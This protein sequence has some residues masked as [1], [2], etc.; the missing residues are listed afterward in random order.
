MK[1]KHNLATRLGG[2]FLAAI[3]LL[4]ILPVSTIAMAVGSGEDV[5]VTWTP[6]TQTQNGTRTVALTAQLV[7]S[8]DTPVAAMVEIS[9]TAEEAGALSWEGE[10]ISDSDLAA[11]SGE[12]TDTDTNTPDTEGSQDSDEGTTQAPDTE[13]SQDSDPE[14]PQDP[15]PDFQDPS[16]DQQEA[17]GTEPSDSD[18][19]TE[20]TETP[21]A[22]VT[23]A[24]SRTGGEQAM[25]IEKSNDGGAVLRI[26]LSEEAYT[27]TKEL[28]FI[29]E[30]DTTIHVYNSDIKVKT[31]EAESVPTNITAVGLLTAGNANASITTSDFTV[32]AHIPEEIEVNASRGTVDLDGEGSKDIAYTVNLQ[33]IA[34]GEGGKDYTLSVALPEGLSLPAGALSYSNS[35][36]SIQ[37][38]ETQIATLKLPGGI[39]IKDD[40]LTATDNSFS[41]IATVPPAGEKETEIE[42]HEITFTLHADKLARSSEAFTGSVSLTVNAEGEGETAMASAAATV[43][44]GGATLPGEGGWN[45]QITKTE[46]LNQN[47]FWRDNEQTSARPE[48]WADGIF[49]ST[50]AKLYYTL[51]DENGVTYERTLLTEDTLKYVGLTSYPGFAV[52]NGHGFTVEDLPHTIQQVDPNDE[53]NVRNTYTIT[54]SLE[55]PE[56]VAGY[57]FR[58]ISESQTGEGKEYPSIDTPGWYYM[59]K[60]SFTFTLNI[61][62]GEEDPLGED[63]ERAARLR[64]LLQNFQFNWS[65][66][67]IEDSNGILD[68]IEAFHAVPSYNEGTITINGMWKYNVDGSPINYSVT[69]IKGDDDDQVTPDYKITAEE[70]GDEESLLEDGEW[71]QI[72]YVNT[73]VPGEGQDT[74]A[75]HSGGT[76]Q[77]VR[78]GNTQYEATKIWL[79]SY[80]D[81]EGN[82]R[83]TANFTLYR[84]R[85]GEDPSTAAQ[86]NGY[87]IQ[88]KNKEAA[89]GYSVQVM[90]EDGETTALADLPKYDTLD[91]A[92]FIYVVR[93]TLSGDNAGQ[94]EQVFGTVTVGETGKIEKTTATL[95][96]GALPDGS[97]DRPAGNTYLYNDGTLTNYQ[98]GTIPVSATKTWLAAAYQST[99]D[100]VAVELTLQYREKDSGG[101]GEWK[102]YTDSDGKSVIRYLH[103]FYAESLSDT[104]MDPPSM[105]QYQ[106]TQISTANQELEYRWLETAVY[107]GAANAEENN[108][109]DATGEIEI[110]YPKSGENS[111]TGNNPKG[112]FNINSSNY[113]V[114]YA[115][116]TNNTQI[117][118][119][120]AEYLDYEVIKEWHKD[121]TPGLIT[122]QIL[123]SVAGGDF[124]E[125]LE[126]TMN[127][128]VGG[129]VTVTGPTTT[130]TDV[131]KEFKI[132]EGAVVKDSDDDT[133][134]KETWNAT[135]SGLPRFDKQGRPYEYLLLEKG[136][137]PTYQTEIDDRGN[138]TTTVING[139]GDGGFNL[140]VRKVWLDD[141]DMEHREPVTFTLY[142]KNNDEPVTLNGIPYTITLGGENEENLWHKVVRI[143]TTGLGNIDEVGYDDKF[144]ADDIYLVE[145]LVGTDKDGNPNKVNHKETNEQAISYNYLYDKRTDGEP[146]F[147]VKTTNHRYQVTYKQE[148]NTSNDPVASSVGAAFTI[149]NRRLGSIDLTVT[150]DWVD[151]REGNSAQVQ[152]QIKAVLENYAEKKETRL[153]LAFR[154]VFDDSM[155]DKSQDCKITYSG[156]SAH[157]DTVCVGGEDVQIYSTYQ[158]DD[159]KSEGYDDP[160]SSEWIILGYVKDEQ[161]NWT[162]TTDNSAQFLGL[163]KYDTNGEIVAYSIEEVWLDV[164]EADKNNPPTVV[165]FDIESTREEYSELYTLWQDFSADYQWGEYDADVDG[166]HTRDE[167]TLKVTNARRGSKT[168]QWTV[169]WQ[170]DFTLNSD[171]RPDIYLDIYQVTY[172]YNDDGSRTP[173]I[174][175]VTGRTLDWDMSNSG[176]WTATMSGVP[177]FDEKGNEI[178]YYAVQR[179]VMAAG[180]YDYQVAQYEINDTALGTRDD[181]AEGVEALNST[182]GSITNTDGDPYNLAVLGKR[183][184]ET[185][186]VE[187]IAWKGNSQQPTNIGRFGETN[188]YPKYALLEGGTIINTLAETYTIEGVKYWTNLPNGWEDSRLPQVTFTVSRH[189][190]DKENEAKE[191]AKVVISSDLWEK[192]RSGTQYKYLIAYE[193]INVLGKESNDENGNGINGEVYVKEVLDMNGEA[194]IK[195]PTP[196]PRYQSGTG[197]L[198]TYT[199]EETVDWGTNKPDDGYKIFDNAPG[200][201]G[202][203]FT[204]NY[205]PTTGSIQVKKYLY[206][207]MT[208]TNAGGM[209]VPESYPAV[210]FRLERWLQNV[211]SSDY[212]PDG[213]S[214][215]ITL[216]SDQVKNI[217]NN[218]NADGTAVT[219]ENLVNSGKS[220]SGDAYIWATLEFADLPLYA[221]DGTKYQYSV[222]EVKTWLNGYDT[223]GVKGDVPEGALD[224]S[225]VE[226]TK[227]N[228]TNGVTESID[229]LTPTTV[230]EGVAISPAATFKNQ[231]PKNQEDF[232]QLTAIKIWED[233]D[234]S[235][236]PSTNDFANLLTLTRTAA[237][238]GGTGGADGI[239][240]ELV[241]GAD[242]TISISPETGTESSQWTITITPAEGKSFEKYAPNGMEWTYT[243]KERVTEKGRLQITE[244]GN[245]DQDKIYTPSTPTPNSKTNGEWQYTITSTT[246]PVSGSDLDT[247]SFGSLTNSIMT[248]AKFEKE[249]VDAE[250][251]PITQDY[252]GFDLTV[253]FQL[254]VREMGGDDEDWV[255]ASVWTYSDGTNAN[256]TLGLEER[257]TGCLSG[258]VVNANHNWTYTFEN[259]PGVVKDSEKKYIFLE[260]RVIETK[261]SWDSGSQIIS[262][263]TDNTGNIGDQDRFTYGVDES[264]ITDATF[265]RSDNTS[266]TTNKLATTSVS[267]TKVWDD[268]NN[269]YGTRPG[270]EGPWSW[271]SWFV[272]QRTTTPNDDNSWTN[273]ALFQ[274]LYGSNAEGKDAGGVSQQGKW[275]DTITGLPTMD[276][277]GT[278]AQKYTYRVRELQPKEDG[279][280]SVNEVISDGE[281]KNI[282]DPNGTYNPD[283]FHYTATYTPPASNSTLWTVTNSMD[284]PTLED[285][286]PKNVEAIKRWVGSDNGSVSSVTFQL[287]Y[288]TE[289]SEW[290]AADFLSGGQWEKTA[291]ASNHWTVRWEDLPDTDGSN[292]QVT[293]YQV[294]EKASNGWVQIGEPVI[295]HDDTTGTTTYSYTFTNSIS[296]SY[297]V[298]KEWLPSTAATHEVTLGLYRTT[299]QEDVG[300]ISGTPV[301]VDELAT[302]GAKRTVTLD[303]I[304]DTDG[305]EKETWKTTFSNLPKYNASGQEY[306]YYAL[307]LDGNNNP[308]VQNGTIVLNNADYEVSYS[309]A[310]DNTKTTVTNTTA[311]SL[312]GTKTWKDDSNEGNTRPTNL[313]LILERRV[314]TDEW[315]EDLAGTYPPTWNKPEGSNEWTYTFS[316]LPSCDS[317]G[318]LYEY[319][320]REEVPTGYK[321]EKQKNNGLDGEVDKTGGNYDFTNIRTGTVS[322]VV[323]KTWVGDNEDDRP[324]NVTLKLERMTIND[325][326]WVDITAGITQPTWTTTGNIWSL[327]YPNLPQFDKDGVR[328]EY[329]ITEVNVPVDY[330][331]KNSTNTDPTEPYTI[332][333]IRKGAL[334]IRKEVSGNRGETDREFHF[335]VTLTGASAAGTQAADVD[336]NYT[337]VYTNQDGTT[338]TEITFT[339]GVSTTEIA[340]KD[341]ESVIISGLPAGLHYEVTETEKNTDGYSTTGTGWTGTIPAGDTAQAEFENYRNSSSSSN[342]TDVS[343]TKTWVDDSDAAGLRPDVLELT[344]YRSVD[345]GPEQVVNAAPTWTKTGNVWTYR[346]ANLPKYDSSGRTYTYRVVETVPEGYVSTVSGNNFTNTLT[347]EEEKI[348]LTGHKSWLGD[349]AEGRPESIT[350]VLYDGDGQV[351]RRVT[352][353][354]AENWSYVFADLPRYDAEGNE[355]PYYVR[356]E[357]V[358]AGYQVSY[359]GL[360]IVNRKEDAVGALRVTKQVT[361]SGAEYDRAFSFTVTLE[362]RTIN[363]T[364]GEMTFVDGVATFTL[365]HGQSVT[366]V[367]LPAGIPYTVTETMPEG[368]AASN[369]QQA[370]EIPASDLAT[371]TVV[372]H[373][374]LPEEPTNPE[375]PEGPENPDVPDSPDDPAGPEDPQGPEVQ[376]GDRANLTL[377]GG[378]AALFAA[379]LA[380]TL[381]WG[382]KEDRKKDD[383]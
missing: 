380:V 42:T 72:Q 157:S 93:E 327:T 37:C 221:P 343:G 204:N 359:D 366:A 261:V 64:A 250:G 317:S 13:D 348:S 268:T 175:R 132:T 73:G 298:E 26:L 325:T 297:S 103:R 241:Q 35:N 192:L 344:L 194:E 331:V 245:D 127:A 21:S 263:P 101:S 288:K 162:F 149:T 68:M 156:P 272:L 202:F 10:T 178:F 168:V 109:N 345:G 181:P 77:L 257:D 289:G 56:N 160:G 16:T 170:D 341:E 164:T 140:L 294:V 19:D 188:N 332:Q 267:V 138:Y 122:I 82:G 123:R 200:G 94:Y 227:L 248:L 225:F 374:D 119:S 228:V 30:D 74:T 117:T 176:S 309:W 311:I 335:T 114:S 230:S 102:T 54:W 252:L 369:A 55:P 60:D 166:A 373:R 213:W 161:G 95:P 65:Y 328:Y 115:G 28:T 217:W 371:V 78:Q 216:T 370:G 278:T 3:M 270:G 206:L 99:F 293:G 365:R 338:N 199:V 218:D 104:L 36:G 382:K 126:F 322:L 315:S 66:A 147:E 11:S 193:G 372:N 208:T 195:N 143:S 9:L 219:E 280:T 139:S 209:A 187:S 159:K 183:A 238:Q 150:K 326:N 131:S 5:T 190:A 180:D 75:L 274:K 85:K 242:Y 342:R 196:L 286:V 351:V 251:K 355:I 334:E 265:S 269:Q 179:T 154:L 191:V 363:G 340:L 210:I 247:Y 110:T 80:G 376:T 62:Q 144:N 8:G 96:V 184:D 89:S 84:Y 302:D 364:Y 20:K 40:S 44:A 258:T 362:D 152:D 236:R 142:N 379:G 182:S 92:E 12:S 316:G 124:Q 292:N 279:Y 301:P 290:K 284:T 275:E 295:T 357:G 185:D 339:G 211:G 231:Q 15:E 108:L 69:E 337:A 58:N 41:F 137:F 90:K 88:L 167:Q 153:A 307:E 158:K 53:T 27:Y 235:F 70:L 287:Q 312:T 22:T 319:R 189:T 128:G 314:N 266:T 145:T 135:V 283:G 46:N 212:A 296:T 146:I 47:V 282:V 197:A 249:W 308:I 244:G 91:G 226:T 43:T 186:N 324:Q 201:T 87:T 329:R 300:S 277:S 174:S 45:V 172:T 76:L 346:Y 33:K 7:Q 130:P 29:S 49:W 264:L 31:Y 129:T 98:T 105:P 198:W 34:V 310:A 285:E 14:T 120:V 59:Q 177:A 305:P 320:V 368:Y 51:T 336:G 107:T 61:R 347:K 330:E 276:Y 349:T 271:A 220:T 111:A 169:E 1:G 155:A 171:L 214:Q 106:T 6:N 136:K 378:L 18:N 239:T 67:D 113:T 234:S 48:G 38:G 125:Y 81:S 141:G 50:N 118:N 321:L 358:P 173:V 205:N 25:L 63:D 318:A 361:G 215:D 350:V 207:P 57:D 112:S 256:Q 97:T 333:N 39:T 304:V 23:A 262:L 240:E 367:G 2:G 223:W 243:L 148:D 116:G 232:E 353:T 255:N 299:A 121:T 383:R 323:N 281:G 24:Q 86:L 354:A 17:D 291:N 163:P 273:V 377:Y 100:D 253:E 32:F 352:V 71:Y 381:Y 134:L 306:Y 224:T 356:E 133:T 259:L 303:G 246:Q 260:Y 165:D 4:S 83:P 313:T 229:S 237:K 254:Q 375:D 222:S 79:D 360:N 151:G 233:N 52:Y 203:T